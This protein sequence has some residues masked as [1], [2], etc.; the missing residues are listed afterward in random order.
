MIHY[1]KYI[2]IAIM[3]AAAITSI[4]YYFKGDK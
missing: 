1:L 2:G 4:A 3:V